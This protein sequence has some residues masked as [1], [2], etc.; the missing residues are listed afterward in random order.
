MSRVCLDSCAHRLYAR[1]SCAHS[2]VPLHALAKELKTT[3]EVGLRAGL[4]DL[5]R[6]GMY[7]CDECCHMTLHYKSNKTLCMYSLLI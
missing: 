5:S 4:V 1:L 3:A 2:R 7:E 6:G